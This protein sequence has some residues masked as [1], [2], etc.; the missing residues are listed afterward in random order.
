MGKE[1]FTGY[2]SMGT[3]EAVQ[4]PP[5]VLAYIGDAVYELLIRLYVLENKKRH[6]EFLHRETVKLVKAKTQAE[7]LELLKPFLDKREFS[8][9]RRAR[10]TKIDNYPKGMELK[11]YRNATA[12]EALV[13]YLYLTGNSKRLFELLDLIEFEKGEVQNTS[14]K[15][16]EN[17]GG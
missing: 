6:V 5:L 4:L 10:N 1:I 13:G 8:I 17:Y 9:I 14:V 16:E 7:A 2:F 15:G 3:K 12:L 11:D